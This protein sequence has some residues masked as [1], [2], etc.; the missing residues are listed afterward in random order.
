M[1]KCIVAAAAKDIESILRWTQ[2]QFGEQA[3]IRYEALLGRAIVNLA[4]N[5][6]RAGIRKRPEISPPAHTYHLWHSRKRVKAS[7]EGVEKP[8]HFI[9]FRV[10]GSGNLEIG[11]VLHDSMELGKHLPAE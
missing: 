2:N 1:L 11:R 3:R 8:R 5:P 9:V 10:S 6:A 4:E 7:V